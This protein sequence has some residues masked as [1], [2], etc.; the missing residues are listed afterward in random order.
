VTIT[1]VR[2]GSTTWHATGRI[3]MS[4]RNLPRAVLVCDGCQLTFS[5][6]LKPALDAAAAERGD[7]ELTPTQEP[8]PSH[9]TVPQPSL[10]GM[11]VPR[12]QDFVSVGE[13]AR[14]RRAADFKQRQTGE[15]S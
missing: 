12:G 1:C 5:S 14:R 10:I 3:V 4:R 13:L 9:L 8:A 7:C 15:A 2:C 6:G 11:Q